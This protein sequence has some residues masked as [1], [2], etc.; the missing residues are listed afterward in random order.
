MRTRLA[1]KVNAILEQY[2]PE[3]RVF[4][5]SD[6]DTRFIRLRPG[7]QIVAFAGSA[8]LVA[9]AIVATAIILMD[10]IGSGNFREQAKRDQR[11]YQARL[12]DL[13]GQR[14]SRAEEALAAQERFNAALKQISLMQSELL[15]SETRRREL[16]TGIDVIQSTLRDTMKDRETARRTLAELQDTLEDGAGQVQVAA[17][18]AP[19]GF[20]AE[21]LE[22]TA[23][24]RDQVV[25]D[26]QDALLEA[27]RMAQQIALMRDQNDAIF[28]QLEEAMTVSVAPLDKMF[29]NAGMPP[30]RIIEQVRRGYSGQGGPMTPLSFTT[31]G[32]EPTAD[33]LRANRLLNQM[34]KLNLYRIA[35]QKAPFANP[36]KTAFRFTSQFG[37]RRDPKTGGRRM[38]SGVDFAAGLGTPLYATADGVVVH[39]GWQSGYGRLVKIQH[40]FGIETRYAHLSRLRVKVGQR[41]SRGQRIGDMGASGRVTGVHLHY[42]VRVGGKAVNPMIYIKAANDVF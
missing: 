6:N 21:A 23:K 37:Y 18:N 34:D 3:R 7:T 4:L 35:A 2:F 33:T 38:H 1:I 26:A 36:V 22:R 27:D 28:R 32:E 41:V 31:R 29:R 39:A 42:E 17:S 19:M 16:E 5:K 24:E 30:D 12:N 9:W 8:A 25:A 11:T 15:Q 20:L 13:S 14:D 10:S 40:E